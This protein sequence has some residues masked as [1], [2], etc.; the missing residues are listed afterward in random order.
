MSILIPR[1]GEHG[2]AGA[3]FRQENLGH[4]ET[5]TGWRWVCRCGHTSDGFYLNRDFAVEGWK[6]HAGIEE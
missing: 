5:I 6:L 2:F 4:G 1:N 3:V